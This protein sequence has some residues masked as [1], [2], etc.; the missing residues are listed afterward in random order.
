MF[1]RFLS[2]ACRRQVGTLARN[3]DLCRDD[4]RFGS[5]ASLGSRDPCQGLDGVSKCIA[6]HVPR[7]TIDFENKESA[8]LG[9]DYGLAV[10][11]PQC[12]TSR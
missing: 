6:C 7:K 4:R 9:A 10:R 1:V 5:F 2:A 8:P 11:S 12:D 3:E